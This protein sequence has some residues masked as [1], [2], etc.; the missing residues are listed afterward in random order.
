LK[1]FR[2]RRGID[3]DQEL[4]ASRPEP[5]PE[6]VAMISDRVERARSRSHGRVRIAFGAGLTAAMLAAVASV[7]GVGFAASSAQKV[8]KSV[9]RITHTS[10]PRVVNRSAAGDQYPSAKVKLCYNGRVISVPKSQETRYR[11]KGAG[12]VSQTAKVG[13][14]CS[15]FRP[16]KKNRKHGAPAFTG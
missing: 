1:S 5:R 16:S 10:H 11:N 8:A 3:L 2:R 14:K 13:S 4:R 9:I 7:G 12:S 6:F 15:N